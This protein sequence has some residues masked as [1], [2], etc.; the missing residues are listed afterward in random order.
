MISLP[1]PVN[2]NSKKIKLL[3]KILIL[4]YKPIF[5]F[6]YICYY[7]VLTILENLA[8][9][10]ISFENLRPGIVM[11]FCVGH[12]K[13]YIW[14]LKMTKYSALK[15]SLGGGEGGCQKFRAYPLD[16]ILNGKVQSGLLTFYMPPNSSKMSLSFPTSLFT[17]HLHGSKL[18]KNGSG[19]LTTNWTPHPV[20]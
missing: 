13:R 19:I 14:V 3:S 2:V 12:G 5:K 15:K 17:F 9:L 6:Y 11:E 4:L 1:P 20:H 7:R 10:G 8:S 18:H 16:I